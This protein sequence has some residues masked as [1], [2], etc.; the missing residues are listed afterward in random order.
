M[1]WNHV[2]ALLIGAAVV[3]L[4]WVFKTNFDVRQELRV[5]SD[6]LSAYVEML[7]KVAEALSESNE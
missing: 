3:A 6:R 1:N 4:A 5:Q 7:A 2:T